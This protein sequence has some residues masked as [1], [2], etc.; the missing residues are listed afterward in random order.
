MNEHLDPMDSIEAKPW[1][2]I[3]SLLGVFAIFL[4]Y[5]AFWRFLLT[6]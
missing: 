3:L 5:M 6:F 4:L 2:L 1:W